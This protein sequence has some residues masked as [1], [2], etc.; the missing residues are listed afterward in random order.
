MRIGLIGCKQIN[1]E[2]EDLKQRWYAV[3]QLIAK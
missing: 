1:A 3:A 2:H